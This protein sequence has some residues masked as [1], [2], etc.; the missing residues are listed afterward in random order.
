MIIRIVCN[1]P[2]IGTGLV[3]HVIKEIRE[4]ILI[5]YSL[6]EIMK[7]TGFSIVKNAL[8]Y[9][10][11]VVEAIRS[12]LPICDEFVVAVGRSDDDTLKLINSIDPEK[13]RIVE[14]EWDES[15]REGGRVLAVETD[16]AFA[17][18]SDDTDWAFYIQGDEVVHERY[19]PSIKAAMEKYVDD[20][21]V[22]GFLFDYLHFYGS[23]DYVGDSF[24]WYPNE[25][26]VIRN[27]KSIYSYKDA[28]GF[29]KGH[30]EKLK[31]VPID[32]YMYHYGWVKEPEAMQRKQ[33]NFNKFWHDDQWIKDNVVKANEFDYEGHIRSLRKFTEGHPDVMKKRI[34]E[35]NWKFDYDISKVKRSTKDKLKGAL[36]R[37]L[38]IDTTHGN[39]ILLKK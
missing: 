14:T 12:I 15:L 7:V 26:R 5:L 32:A 34:E 31:V 25:I 11:P 3:E 36:K 16:K 24:S 28:Q 8:I 37:Y 21:E 18:I 23:Y 35:K 39:Y 2:V 10:Y 20:K 6:T 19:L 1:L 17:A 9:D 38:G 13:I 30:N 29:R 27:D 33:E 4:G 22:D